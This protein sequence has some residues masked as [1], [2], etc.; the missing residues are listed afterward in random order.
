M[1]E[2][3]L[4]PLLVKRQSALAPPLTE[5]RKIHLKSAAEKYSETKI[6]KVKSSTPKDPSLPSKHHSSKRQEY[7]EFY[8]SSEIPAPTKS[9]I[10]KQRSRHRRREKSEEVSGAVGTEQKP[11]EMRAA[12]Y[13]NTKYDQYNYNM[14]RPKYVPEDTSRFNP[15]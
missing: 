13:S 1:P 7:A 3:E 9:K 4:E 6:A 11:L 2:D 8:G 10:Q 5:T 12:G 14:M 15:H